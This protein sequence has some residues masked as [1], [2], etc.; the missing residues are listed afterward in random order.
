MSRTWLGVGDTKGVAQY[1][2]VQR[3]E[4]GFHIT[5]DRYPFLKA[6]M[7][8]VVNGRIDMIVAKKDY[9]SA[10]KHIRG[11]LEGFFLKEL[12]NDSVS[13][14]NV[15]RVDTK[16][17]RKDTGREKVEVEKRNDSTLRA[18]TGGIKPTES[19]GARSEGV[20]V[21]KRSDNADSESVADRNE[22]VQGAREEHEQS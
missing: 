18:R 9:T 20:E 6:G 2:N 15:D 8:F 5:S 10:K 11:L 3:I 21:V 13:T 17:P 22:D 19:A 14:S 7:P 4:N 1:I 16:S 12:L